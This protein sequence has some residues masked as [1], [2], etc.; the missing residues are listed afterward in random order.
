MVVPMTPPQKSGEPLWPVDTSSQMS[1][2]VA[3]ASLGDIPASISPIA[4]VSRTRSVT[5][6]MDIMELWTNANKALNDLLTTKASIDAWRWRAVWELGIVLC[7]NESQA[8]GSIKEAKAVCSQ[9]TLDAWI[10]CS[11]LIL[12]AKT[13][14]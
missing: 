14:C 6:P 12:E 11:W 8:A 13:A 2:Q 10:T 3:E 5:P 1:V 7:Q 4:A 9:V